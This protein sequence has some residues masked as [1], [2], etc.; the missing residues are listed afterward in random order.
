MLGRVA[1]KLGSQWIARVP[2][3]PYMLER[4]TPVA[5][6]TFDDFPRTA[7]T[8][9]GR[10]LEDAGFRGTYFVSAAFS[11]P[12]MR[13]QVP[14]GVLEGTEYYEMDDLV[15]LHERGHEL[16]SHSFAHL[17]VPSQAKADIESSIVDNAR[18]IRATIGEELPL[19]SYAYPQGAVS[20]RTRSIVSRHFSSCRGTSPG[21]NSGRIDLACLRAI[22]IDDRFDPR[23]SL[24]PMI[25]EAQRRNGWLIFC[26]HDVERRP[27]RWG[28]TPAVFEEIVRQV[29]VARLEVASIENVAPRRPTPFRVGV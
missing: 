14:F 1:R 26:M 24:Q 13:D 22:C 7:W 3:R 17:R 25:E 29:R 19:H 5:S 20:V 27:S 21:I 23:R 18:F 16:G 2:E 28:C 8:V 15:Q 11:P 12:R 10:I 6:F 4:S 9:G